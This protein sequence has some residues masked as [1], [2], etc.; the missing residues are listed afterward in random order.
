MNPKS[1][2]ELILMNNEHTSFKAA[3]KTLSESSLVPYALR[4]KPNDIYLI[5]LTAYDLNIP[6]TQALNSIHVIQGNPTISGQMMLGL[7]RAKF[8]NAYIVFSEVEEGISCTMARDRA[9]KEEGF[10]ATWTMDRAKQMGL[11]GKD[12]WVKQATTMLRW[13]AVSEAARIVFPDVLK[14]LYT[15]DEAEDI[16]V[17]ETENLENDFPIP[18]IEKEPG[19]FYRFQ[20]GK[21]RGMQLK[22]CDP[23]D[24]SSYQIHL[25]IKLKKSG[26]KEWQQTVLEMITDYIDKYDEYHKDVIEVV[27]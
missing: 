27:K 11:T 2:T 7:I 14:G 18:E 5:G 25:E 1:S 4:K 6:L 22:D 19:L 15:Q 16:P 8:E 23:D 12:N 10:T 17:G 24:L 20:N 21:F 9:F 26:L 13:R 3:C